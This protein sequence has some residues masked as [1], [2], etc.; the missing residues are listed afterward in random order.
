MFQYFAAERIKRT[1]FS[2]LNLD[3]NT[4]CRGMASVRALCCSY[5][6]VVS[7][8]RVAVPSARHWRRLR[9]ARE[10]QTWLGERIGGRNDAGFRTGASSRVMAAFGHC[11]YSRFRPFSTADTAPEEFTFSSNVGGR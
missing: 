2:N 11:R 1:N 5:G 9:S 3:P 10:L 6:T 8:H 7:A 4:R